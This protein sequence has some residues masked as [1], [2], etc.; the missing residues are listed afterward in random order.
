[1]KT[2]ATV[3]LILAALLMPMTLLGP[4]AATAGSTAA[5]TAINTAAST[6]KSAVDGAAASTAMIGDS[7]TVRGSDELQ[8]IT[9]DGWITDGVGGRPVTDTFARID[10]L[11]QTYGDPGAVV[12]ALG[13][14]ARD[15]WTKADY[16]RAALRFPAA[17]DVFFVTV[18]WRCENSPRWGHVDPI[19]K[20]YSRWMN[21]IA[22]D[23]E[24]VH[25]IPWRHVVKRTDRARLGDC[26]HAD[27]DDGSELVWA[28]VVKRNVQR[29]G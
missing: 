20:R 15:D 9:S 18:A 22:N 19:M 24:N 8:K 10:A 1:M 13:S 2:T 6:T 14:N 27:P 7:L 25:V 4:T 16:R 17:T 3:P 21:Q 12:L 28:R 23:L 5:S 11:Q 26:V 29:K